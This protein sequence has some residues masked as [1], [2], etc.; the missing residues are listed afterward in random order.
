MKMALMNLWSRRQSSAKVLVSLVIIITI[1]CLFFTYLIALEDTT[2]ELIYSYRSGHY[3]LV[4]SEN[5]FTQNDRI[6][7]DKIN[8]VSQKQ[9]YSLYSPVKKIFDYEFTINDESW[10]C[11]HSEYRGDQPPANASDIEIVFHRGGL[12]FYDSGE[13]LITN[14]D[15][16]EAKYRW[17]RYSLVMAGKSNVRANE[18]IVS[19]QFIKEFGL[20]SEIID[21]EISINYNGKE[22]DNIKIVGIMDKKYYELTGNITAPQ[23]I[24]SRDSAIYRDYYESAQMTHY[25]ELNINDYMSVRQIANDITNYV[26]TANFTL[27]STYGLAMAST[28]TIVN[29]VLVGVMVTVGIGIVAALLLNII[30]NTRYMIVKKANYYGIIKAYGM[31]NKKIFAV[32]F[33]EIFILLVISIL[34]AYGLS[35]GLAFILNAA[36]SSMLGIGVSFTPLNF[37]ITFAVAITSS[38]ALLITVVSVNYLSVKRSSCVDLLRKSIDL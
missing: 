4:D 2:Q 3:Y 23:I 11:Y 9:Y 32:M 28:V 24:L 18:V 33:Y 30:V 8:N 27:G 31:K 20:T 36:L 15:I 1:L 29:T 19:S 26:G 14:N 16:D 12:G 34:L 38:I 22:Y 7:M 37:G 6:N 21:K 17:D 25:A 5:E 35:Y 13:E 10:R